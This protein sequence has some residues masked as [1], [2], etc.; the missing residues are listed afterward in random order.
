MDSFYN[1]FQKKYP[2]FEEHLK[3]FPESTNICNIR[4]L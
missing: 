3:T 2:D 4:M 1:F